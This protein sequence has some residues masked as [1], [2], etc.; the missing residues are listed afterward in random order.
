MTKGFNFAAAFV[1]A[2]SFLRGASA[3][4][5]CKAVAL[6]DVAAVESPDDI[7]PR[8]AYDDAI[9]QYRVDKITGMTTFCSHGGYCYPTQ[10][11]INGEKVQALRL[12]NCEVGAK[13]GELGN[14]V[15]YDVEVVRSKNSPEAL[16]LNDLD[17]RFLEMGLCSAC[18][19]SVAWFYVNKPTSRCAKL[20][21]DALEG[22]P[23]AEQELLNSPEYCR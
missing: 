6:R 17:N 1:L 2:S 15:Y 18:A 21:K 10:V 16:R 20:A 22:N 7:L 11:R 5:L 3:A 14:E 9:T 12:V 23:V 19:G 8:G 4:D 13:T